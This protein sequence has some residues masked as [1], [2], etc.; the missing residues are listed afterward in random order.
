MGALFEHP[1][2]VPTTSVTLPSVS[3]GNVEQHNIKTKFS[4]SMNG[5]R[6]TT[7][8]TAPVKLLVLTITGMTRTEMDSF[9]AFYKVAHCEQIRFTDHDN[10]I[11]RGRLITQP[12]ELSI[13]GRKDGACIE[14]GSVSLQFEGRVVATSIKR[15]LE[16]G[17]DR[18]TEDGE[19]RLLECS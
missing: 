16:D 3:L 1:Y 15:L 13:D 19:V 6:Y 4:L 18:L 11:W 17:C 10:L 8:Y 5:T 12:I 2:A 14:V 9:I 7:R